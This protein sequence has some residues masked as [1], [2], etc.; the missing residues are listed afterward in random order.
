LCAWQWA[1]GF[2]KRQG[3]YSVATTLSHSHV[4]HLFG[5]SEL[6]II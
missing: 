5:I 6:Q 2:H 4:E 1:S 3:I